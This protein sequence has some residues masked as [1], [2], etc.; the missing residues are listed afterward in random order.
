MFRVPQYSDDP[1]GNNS[2]RHTKATVHAGKTADFVRGTCG[3][4]YG[5]RKIVDKR[6]TDNDIEHSGLGRFRAESVLHRGRYAELLVGCFAH[7]EPLERSPMPVASHNAVSRRL[8]LKRLLSDV[9]QHAQTRLHNEIRILRRLRQLKDAAEVPPP[10]HAGLVES[11]ADAGW[12]ATEFLVGPNLAKYLGGDSKHTP[13]QI[14][15]ALKASAE[16]LASLHQAGCIHGDWKPHNLVVGPEGLASLSAV[17][18]G[19]SRLEADIADAADSPGP[20]RLAGSPAFMA[21]E[22]A[23]SQRL[24]DRLSDI[25]SW[26]CMA[27]QLVTG[28]LP[29]RGQTSIE[30]CWKQATQTAPQIEQ[31]KPDIPRPLAELIMSCLEK[32]AEARPQS[33][34][35]LQSALQDARDW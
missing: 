19:L 17:D 26:G 16:V 24:P 30:I 1:T 32:T 9:P 29:F 21:P 2:K 13:I 34:E 4:R 35:Q 20:E 11:D 31:E 7:S 33:A 6:M 25:Y 23:R 22:I 10:K 18:F 8:A 3:A 14:L 12:L 28:Q 5:P 27:Y 15:L